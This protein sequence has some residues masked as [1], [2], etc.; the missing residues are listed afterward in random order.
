[1]TAPPLLATQRIVSN[2]YVTVDAIDEAL[3]TRPARQ[4]RLRAVGMPAWRQ[5]EYLAG[6]T[7]LRRLLTEVAGD[8]AAGPIE[9]RS[10]GQ[11]YLPGRPGLGISLSHTHDLVAAAVGVGCAVGVDVE[12][13]AP[14][15]RAMLRRCCTPEALA[16]LD[17]LPR[18]AA[19]VEF[20]WLWTAKEACVKAAGTGLAGAPWLIPVPPGERSGRWGSV[21]WHSLRDRSTTPVT[22]AYAQSK[23]VPYA[24]D[25]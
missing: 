21:R 12:A 17:S 11:P 19:D 14:V 3:S 25:G 4:D 15:S 18:A 5:R 24:I 9:A 22:C 13:A 16:V 7:L 8:A 1:M 20:A 2:V 10:S 23:E 6:R